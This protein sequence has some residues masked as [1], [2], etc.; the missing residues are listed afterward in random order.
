MALK[1]TI[2]GVLIA[3]AAATTMTWSA[4]AAPRVVAHDGAR[5]AAVA[6]VARVAASRVASQPAENTAF[7]TPQWVRDAVFYQIFPDRFCN[8]D[9]SN[10]PPGCEAWDHAPRGDN[11]FGGDLQGVLDKLDYLQ[12]LGVNAIYFNPIFEASTNHKYDTT[13]YHKIE[14]T[15]GDA[16]LLKRLVAECHRRG[17]RVILDGVFNHVGVHFFAFQD[18]LAHGEKSRYKDWFFIHSYPVRMHPPNYHCWWNI[19][20]L[21]KLNTDNPEVH[22]YLL[23]VA[24]SWIREADI[25]G[26]RLDVPNEVPHR[27]WVDFRR[28]VKALKPD[29]YI[30]GEIWSDGRPWLGGD[31]FDAVMNYQVRDA[32]LSLLG[33]RPEKPE[34]KRARKAHVGDVAWL[35]HRLRELEHQVAPQVSAVQFNLLGSHDTERLLTLLGDD[36]RKMRL[37]YALLLSQPGAPVI[38]YGDEIGMQ[39]GRDPDCRRT[40]PWQQPQSWNTELRTWLQRLIAARQAHAALRRGTTTTLHAADGIY[41]FTRHLANE[42]VLV[43]LNASGRSRRVELPLPGAGRGSHLRRQSDALELRSPPS[44]PHDARQGS[45]LLG[46]SPLSVTQGRLRGTLGAWQSAWLLLQ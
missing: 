6:A 22:D 35:D 27:F 1:K 24:T 34:E 10:D 20:S 8:G 28:A 46:D 37:A 21:P 11:F 40:F 2:T 13:D 3:M 32:I 38:Y 18:V 14:P 19:W 12:D 33:A 39:G 5:G 16:E 43:A 45:S 30:V 9:T 36:V 25:D 31:Q 42:T 29:A 7:V 15:F 23:D 26:W 41:V 17:M 4:P 44:T